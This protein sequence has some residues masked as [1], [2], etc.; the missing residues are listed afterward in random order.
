LQSDLQKQLNKLE[1]LEKTLQ[2]FI[3]EK[4]AKE[5]N[6]EDDYKKGIE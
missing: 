4:D 3:K 6:N 2:E 5:N 1:T